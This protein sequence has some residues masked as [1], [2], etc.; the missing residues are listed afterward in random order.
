MTKERTSHEDIE[1]NAQVIE[2]FRANGNDRMLL[3]T[4]TGRKSGRALTAPAIFMLDGDRPVIA[5]SNH[6][7]ES[8]PGWY[9]NLLADPNVTVE[10]GNEQYEATAIVASGADRERLLKMAETA[11]PFVAEYQAKTS[12]KIQL[13]A[14]ERKR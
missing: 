7:Y 1:R 10:L 8:H 12:R 3:L 14:L 6:G 4:T 9:Y 11:L 5:G 2:N 13:V